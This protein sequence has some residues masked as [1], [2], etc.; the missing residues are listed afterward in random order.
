MFRII[1]DWYVL[2]GIIGVSFFLGA[3]LDAVF[4][5]RRKK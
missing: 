5:L 2:V 4:D 1:L 3:I